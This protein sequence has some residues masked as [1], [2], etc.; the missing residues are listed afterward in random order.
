[1][2]LSYKKKEKY[3][4]DKFSFSISYKYLFLDFARANCS[5][6]ALGFWLQWRYYKIKTLF[7]Y[8]N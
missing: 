1:M 8:K 3:F 5:Y 2:F 4:Y 7:A 6:I